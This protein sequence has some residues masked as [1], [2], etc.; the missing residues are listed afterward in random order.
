[1]NE[2]GGSFTGTGSGAPGAGDVTHRTTK[3]ALFLPSERQGSA[4]KALVRFPKKKKKSPKLLTRSHRRNVRKM[5]KTNFPN[6]FSN[7]ATEFLLLTEFPLSQPF[8]IGQK[9]GSRRFLG[10][11]IGPGL[12]NPPQDLPAPN[13]WRRTG[14]WVMRRPVWHGHC[15]GSFFGSLQMLV[16]RGWKCPPTTLHSRAAP[17]LSLTTSRPEPPRPARGQLNAR[18]PGRGAA[19]SGCSVHCGGRCYWG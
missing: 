11:L 18:C 14:T 12:T 5:E 1:M 19:H 3:P 17:L 16:E 13:P 10:R 2:T 7:A 4:A 15:Q 8:S 9:E 6:A